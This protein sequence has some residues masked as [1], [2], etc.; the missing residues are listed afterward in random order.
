MSRKRFVITSFAYNKKGILLS[1]SVNDYNAS[2]PKQKEFSIKAGL[3][4]ERVYLHSE[5]STLIKARRN[6]VHTLVVQRFKSDGSL[7][8]A[9]P[10]ASCW[11]AIKEFDVKYV[12]YST[13][14]GFVKVKV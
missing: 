11:L 2:H 3:H 5:L 9:K 4:S 8:L 13:E 7:A 14:E 1:S 6:Q 10:C 12:M